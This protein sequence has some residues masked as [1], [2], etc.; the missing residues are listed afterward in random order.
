MTNVG[1]PR[2]DGRRVAEIA[3]QLRPDLAV[4]LV[5]GYARKAADRRVFLD[6]GMTLITKLFASHGFAEEVARLLP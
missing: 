4:A 3:R 6:P 5:T 1:L 2:I